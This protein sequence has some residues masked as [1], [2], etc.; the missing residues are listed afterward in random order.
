MLLTRRPPHA[1]VYPVSGKQ[2]GKSES[3]MIR[4]LLKTLRP[5]QW[6][7]NVFIFAALVFDSKLLH[8]APLL[9]T[10]AGFV[11]FC[12]LSSTIYIIND[13]VDLEKDRQHPTKR[14]RPL[15]SG[16]L[17][18]RVAIVA[19][20]A[21]GVVCLPLSFWLEPQ[22]GVIVLGYVL[23]MI[24][25]SFVLKNIL[26]ID[27]M[28]IAAGFVLR[29]MAGVVL[30]HVERFS[31]WLYVCT[32]LI[33]LFIAVGKRRNELSL[34]RDNANAHRAILD[35]YSMEFIDEMMTILSAATL[36]AYSLYTFSAE[37][38]PANHTMML[39]IPFV[40][41]GLFRYLYLVHVRNEGG[42]PEEIVLG[43]KPLIAT[44]GLWGLAAVAVL[45]IG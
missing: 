4:P 33:A 17:S 42:A 40:L 14:N 37:N 27:V 28:T 15:A 12:L 45:Y 36:I 24:A 16:R 35:E 10:L 22:F 30:V 3:S 19:A 18:P 39:T 23:M 8:T 31:P 38:L 13:L 25:Y 21:I 29:V 41:Y 2:G 1:I 9:R 34:L 20:I 11:L 26:L 32:T 5:K 7:K 43:D 6:I 44:V